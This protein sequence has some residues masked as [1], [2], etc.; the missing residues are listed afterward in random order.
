MSSL[1]SGWIFPDCK[2]RTLEVLCGK[3]T[4]RTYYESLS[5]KDIC[6][7]YCKMLKDES[8]VLED[9]IHQL[10]ERGFDLSD[11]FICC[12][13][14]IKVSFIDNIDFQKLEI[15]VR[16]KEEFPG[17]VREYEKLEYNISC[18]SNKILPRLEQ[19]GK[20]FNKRFLESLN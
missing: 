12:L 7:Q 6:L 3:K 2:R 20:E 10:V 5:H 18:C 4:F 1:N 14:W 15:N 8:N 11:I 13:G 17:I 16:C 9:Q 19:P